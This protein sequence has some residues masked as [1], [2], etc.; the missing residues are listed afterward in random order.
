MNILN[1]KAG[2]TLMEVL[3]VVV[4]ITILTTMGIPLYRNHLERQKAAIGVTNLRMFADSIERYTALHGDTL[5]AD[6]DFTK[7]DLDVDTSKITGTG[8]SMRYD[9]DFF[10][11][12]IDYTGATP[13][14]HALRHADLSNGGYSLTVGLDDTSDITCISLDSDYCS[15]VLHICNN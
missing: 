3:I 9:D 12:Q 10:T 14:I 5:P 7:L 13:S 1:K 2:Y 6:F 4:I 8:H 11:Y 15:N